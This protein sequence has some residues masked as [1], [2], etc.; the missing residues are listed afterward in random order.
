MQ[1]IKGIS[2]IIP[3]PYTRSELVDYDSLRN[4]LKNRAEAGVHAMT[5]FGIAGEYYKQSE[6]E[7]REM[8]RVTVDECHKNN[9][10]VVVSVTPHGTVPAINQARYFEELGADCIMVLPPFFMKPNAE[11]IYN[12]VKSIAKSVHSPVMVQYAPEQTGVTI[13]PEVWI[14][15]GQECENL[16]YYKIECKPNGRYISDMI[17]KMKEKPSIFIGNCGYQMLE[18]FDRG[19]VGSMPCLVLAEVYLKVYEAYMRGDREEAVRIHNDI[20]PLYNHIHQNVEMSIFYEKRMMQRRG[21]IETD[22]CRS[23]HFASDA[24]YDK[25]FDQYFA[26]ISEKYGL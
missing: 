22:C 23:P 24:E 18:G 15:L 7:S 10:P 26:T 16:Q 17:G 1:R 8:A 9:V 14:R 20:L 3:T 13:S 19:A 2:P 6:A 5:L 11:M 12:H 25:L 21:I 4:M